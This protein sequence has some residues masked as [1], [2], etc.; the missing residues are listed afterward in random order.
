VKDLGKIVLHIP[1][2]AGSK[3]VPNKNIRLMNDIPMIFYSIHSSIEANI[4][5]DVYLNTDS[6]SLIKIVTDHYKIKTYKRNNVLAGDKSSSDDFNYDIIK[7]LNPNTLIMINPVCPLIESTDIIGAISRYQE[8]DCDTL[9]SAE[10]STMQAFK[11]QS[12]INIKLDEPLAPSQDNERVFILN[13]A[14]TIW[15]AK[16]FAERMKTS[17]YAVLGNRR[18]F[19]ELDRLKSIKV[20]YENDFLLAEKL[21]SMRQTNQK[22]IR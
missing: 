19:F 14:I 6:D 20:S 7:S 21:L 5:E 1:A 10:S 11:S 8:S 13:W 15:D 18:E 16:K 2:R 3:R 9:I 22:I 17:G 12:P 4:T